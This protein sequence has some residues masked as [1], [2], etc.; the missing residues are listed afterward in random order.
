VPFGGHYRI[1]DITLSNCIN[2]GLRKSTS[3]PNTKHSRSTATFA[4]AGP[5]RGQELGEF[6]EILPPM[7]RTGRRG[8]WE[9]LTRCIRTSIP[10]AASSQVHDHSFRRSHLQNGL[11]PDDDYTRKRRRDHAGHPSIARMKCA[12]RR[13]RGRQTGEVLGF[14]EKP[15]HFLRSPSTQHRRRIHGIYIFNTETLLKPHRR[16]RRSNSKH[17][18]AQHFAQPLGQKK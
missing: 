18:F 16:R 14:E 3:S 10:S 7:Q 1:I 17:D 2:S 8:T 13:G 4:K 12:V 6:F 15:C 11:Q 9:P 5:D